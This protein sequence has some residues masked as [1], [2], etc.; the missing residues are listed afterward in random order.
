MNKLI[1]AAAAL[2][3]LVG[4][5]A[6]ADETQ[7]GQGGTGQYGTQQPGTMG[8]TMGNPT[9]QNMTGKVLKASRDSVTI[10]YNGAAIPFDVTRQTQFQGV[11]SAKDLQEGQQVRA[12]FDLKKD[13]NELRSISVVGAGGTGSHMGGTGGMGGSD[14]G[15]NPQKGY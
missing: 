5:N 4:A 3:L 6:F 8:S 1:S 7:H 12:N 11:T 10:E 14:T 15:Q 13:K 9:T 2:T